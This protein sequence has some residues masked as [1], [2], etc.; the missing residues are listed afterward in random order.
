MY[1]ADYTAIGGYTK[2]KWEQPGA[3]ELE[4]YRRALK[5]NPLTIVRAADDG[6]IQV[7]HNKGCAAMRDSNA[8]GGTESYD[9][10]VI[11]QGDWWG[12]RVR[13]ADAA[14][15]HWLGDTHKA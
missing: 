9:N 12:T 15:M 1:L 14:A 4:F 10:C 13:L 11:M 7:Y 5:Q 3:A 6:L 2:S 8:D